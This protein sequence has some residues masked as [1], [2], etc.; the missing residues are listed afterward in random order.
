VFDGGL[1]LKMLGHLWYADKCLGDLVK[2]TEAKLTRPLFA[3]TGDHYGRKFINAR[4]DYFESSGVPFILYGKD[5]LRGINIPPGAAGAHIDIPPTL[6]ELAAPKGFE[7]HS[8][9]QDLLAPRKEFLGI[10]FFKV[11]GKDFIFDV[12]GSR[13]YPLPG[14]ELPEKLPDVNELKATFD[15]TYGV[16]WWRVRRGEKF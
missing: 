6:I 12:K 16:G 8:V 5:V 11:I 10:G 14:K 9:G 1:S 15:H 7:Y 13:V 3:F 4:P 2:R